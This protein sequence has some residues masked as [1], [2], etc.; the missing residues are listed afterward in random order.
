MDEKQQHLPLPISSLEKKGVPL[1][2][3]PTYESGMEDDRTPFVSRNKKIV[4]VGFLAFFAW[5]YYHLFTLPQTGSDV[6]GY[7][8][9][10][11][12][13]CAHRMSFFG[14]GSKVGKEE[15]ERIVLETPLEARIRQSS[16]DYTAYPHAAGSEGDLR[17]ALYV[18]NKWESILGLPTTAD[19]ENIFDAGT[20]EAK[21]ALQGP[22]SHHGH[23]HHHPHHPDHPHHPPPPPED[24]EMEGTT[25]FPYRSKEH[26]WK[27][28]GKDEGEEE[29]LDRIEAALERKPW[30]RVGLAGA[31]MEE[32]NGR[33]KHGHDL[34]R[35]PHLGGGVG[36][37]QGRGI[38][39]STRRGMGCGTISMADM[40]TMIRRRLILLAHAFI[41][42]LTTPS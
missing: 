10:R 22:K 38:R 26:G 29:T 42:K 21:L 19:D 37:R 20:K 7:H 39:L 23:H 1:P 31:R 35:H 33:V 27:W 4:T 13:G 40:A 30:M 5:T 6:H 28:F 34:P 17:S 9:L 2:P 36:I 3:P 16:K 12:G 24:D 8:S 32:E 11:T 14:P 25:A 15:A 18:K 41:S